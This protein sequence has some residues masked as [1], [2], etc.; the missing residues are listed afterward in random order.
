M[1]LTLSSDDWHAHIDGIPG[2][3]VRSFDTP[4]D[5]AQAYQDAVGAGLVHRVEI[6]GDKR[7]LTEDDMPTIP[8]MQ[9][10]VL[11]LVRLLFIKESLQ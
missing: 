1:F 9:G 5:A 6:L 11:F 2:S 4:E 7:V 10:I 8:G 3:A